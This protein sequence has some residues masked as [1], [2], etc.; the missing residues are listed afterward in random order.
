MRASA[1]SHLKEGLIFNNISQI[2]ILIRPSLY[3]LDS[4]LQEAGAICLVSSSLFQIESGVPGPCGPY[5]GV[6][7]PEFPEQRGLLLLVTGGRF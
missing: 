7:A 5:C 1:W 3:L 2:L 6:P 4:L